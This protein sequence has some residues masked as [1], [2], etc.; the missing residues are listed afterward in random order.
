[1]WIQREISEALRE[2]AVTRQVVVVTGGRQTGKTAVLLN[3]FPD[4]AYVSLD[5]PIIAEEAEEDGA[6]FLDRH[7]A[8]VILDEVQNAPSIFASVNAHFGKPRHKSG[9]IVLSS[10]RR[11]PLMS[12]LAGRVGIVALHS[13]SLSELHRW[14]GQ[15][16][17]REQILTWC[18][19]GGYPELHARQLSPERFFTSLV[20]TY[21]ERVVRTTFNV[22]NLVE[23][24]RFLGLLA[25]QS[26]Q[27]LSSNGMATELGVS[28]NTVRSWLDVLETSG[29]IHMVP[30]YFPR[31]FGKRI[32]KTPKV[33]FLDTGLLCFLLGIRTVKEL[34]SSSLLGSIFETLVYGQLVRWHSNR[35]LQT[36]IYFF[37]DHSGREADFV[38]PEGDRVILFDAKLNS[39]PDRKALN[40]VEEVLGKEQ[41]SAKI[42]VTPDSGD[43]NLP[44][45]GVKLRGVTYPMGS[46]GSTRP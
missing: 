8:P 39:N 25:R 21:L 17:T 9:Q 27:L 28:H 46:P 4:L 36:P 12:G 3:A 44:K 29:I 6:G 33:M 13:L 31:N 45:S 16:L 14:S 7:P 37:R 42:L 1:V 19:H 5:L 41:V 11:F 38:I 18:L 20:A 22:R 23:F 34:A 10:S 35:L 43:V 15:K 26:G 24:H 32:I 40:P 30:P 2:Q